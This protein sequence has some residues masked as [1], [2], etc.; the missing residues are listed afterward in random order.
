MKPSVLGPAAPANTKDLYDQDF[1]EWTARNAEL[2][3]AGRVDEADLGH[4][5]EEIEDMGRSER[6]ELESRVAVLLSHLLKWQLQPGRRG[7]SW[8][9]T[10]RVQRTELLRLL[11][12]SP[13][14]KP[15]LRR[16]LSELYGLAIDRAVGETEL[17]DDVFPPACPFSLDQI[18]APG[19]FPE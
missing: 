4:I 16:D 8:Q 9:A 14:L 13:S 1:F 15:R 19:F 7:R 11:A 17:P 12:E 3:R 10:I 2:L 5:A 18:L 6:R